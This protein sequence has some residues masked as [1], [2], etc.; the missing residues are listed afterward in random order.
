MSPLTSTLCFG[1]LCVFT[2]YLLARADITRWFWGWFERPA[3]LVPTPTLRE[4]RQGREGKLMPTTGSNLRLILAT[5][6]R[7]PA[8]TGFWIGLALQHV[9]RPFAPPTALSFLWGGVWGLLLTPI[10]FA[11]FWGAMRLTRVEE[12]VEDREDEESFEIEEHAPPPTDDN[13]T[14]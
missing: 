6:L 13:P 11:P 7:C 12:D 10:L 1:A 5:M 9:V 4:I 8:C 2:Y 14:D 3:V